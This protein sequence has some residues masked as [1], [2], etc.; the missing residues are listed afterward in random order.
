MMHGESMKHAPEGHSRDRSP[1]PGAIP[2]KHGPDHHGTGNQ[3]VAE[4]SHNRMH[5]PGRGFEQSSRRVLVYTDLKSLVP[6]HDQRAPEREIEIHLTGHM[7][8]Y[9]WSFDGKKYSDAPEP[10]RVRYGER[11]RFTFVNDTMMEHPLHLHGMWMQL[12]NGCRLWSAPMHPGRGPSTATFS[13][14]WKRECSE[15]SRSLPNEW[16]KPRCVSCPRPVVSRSQCG[17]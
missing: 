9:M 15:S 16:E 8:R 13:C 4:Y 14:T 7:Q 3:T 1:I 12:E 17:C 10:I 5:E 2:V 6:Y 11:V